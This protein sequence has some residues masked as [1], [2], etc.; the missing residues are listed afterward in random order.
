MR[1]LFFVLLFGGFLSLATAEPLLLGTTTIVADVVRNIAGENFQVAALIPPETDPHA[2]ELTPRDLQLLLSADFIFANGAGLEEGLEPFLALPEIRGK[3]VDLSADLPLRPLD[4][5]WDPHV[6]LDPTLVMKWTEKIAAALSQRFPEH[7]EFFEARAERYRAELA[8][9]DRWIQEEVEKI[10]AERRLLVTD[11]FSLG[12]FAVRY[13]FSE[14]G[15]L[16]PSE[17]SLAEPSAQELAEL[18]RKMRELRVPAI[19]ISPAFNRALA[20][21]VAAE[22]GAQVVI[23]Y[24][25]ALSGPEG[26]APDYLSLMRENVRRIVE[27]LKP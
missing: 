24:I 4:G 7:A 27:A 26:P 12:Y 25:G 17:S 23:L 11:H 13:G 19:F 20:E 18:V 22:A 15:A 10:P 16:V 6:W 14:V 3:V 8:A 5:G 21:R 1:A 9:L 2:F